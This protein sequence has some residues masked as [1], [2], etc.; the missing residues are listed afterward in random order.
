VFIDTAVIYC[1]AGDGGN[2]RVSFRREKYVARG[3]PDGGDGGNGGNIYF[4]ADSSIN[5]LLNFHYSR[6]FRAGNGENGGKSNM[7]GKNGKDVVIKVPRGTII[8]DFETQNIIADIFNEGEKV[9]ILKGGKGG[10]GNARFCT[11]TRRAPAF[12]ENGETTVE[13]KFLLELKTIADVGLV[14]YPNAGKS[15][16]LS[17]ISAAKPKIASYPFTTL[18]PNL[19]TVNYYD[20]SFIVADIPGLIEGA[21]D[22]VGLGHSFLRHVERVRLIVHLVDISGGGEGRKP[23]EDYKVIREELKKYSKDLYNLPEIVAVN[24][25]DILEDRAV[26]EEFIKRTKITPVEI[27]AATTQGVKELTDKI[28]QKLKELPPVEPLVFTP[29]EY[30]EEDKQS[31]FI[32]KR[33]DTYYV[34]GGFIRE[35]AKKVY[36][37]DTESFVYFQR[38]MRE[39]GIIDELRKMGAKDGDTVC[40]IDVEFTLV[41]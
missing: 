32:E 31:F 13:R 16:L 25:I 6:H 5:T 21:A 23:W 9:L 34:D 28:A 24:K 36:L 38:K 40:V 11:P 7:T 33:G 3:G 22:G 8:K 39:R 41:D 12:A 35:L 4:Q 15:T 1:K 19:G 27:S 30:E 2:G 20:Q 26:I 10:R 18:S 14:G 29:Y 17:V 37:D